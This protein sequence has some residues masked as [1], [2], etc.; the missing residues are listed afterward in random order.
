M[1]NGAV[2]SVTAAKG[3]SDCGGAT[4]APSRRLIV[5]QQAAPADGCAGPLR[6]R[7]LPSSVRIRLR[8]A[9]IRQNITF[10]RVRPPI[11]PAKNLAILAG[12]VIRARHARCPAG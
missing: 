2:V 3:S 5:S 4:D 9:F 10:V 7:L 12:G 8:I 11:F 6:A 1:R